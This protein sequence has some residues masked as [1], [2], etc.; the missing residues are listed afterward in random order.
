M[1]LTSQ[2][3]KALYRAMKSAAKARKIKLSA[4][5]DLYKRADPYFYHAFWWPDEMGSGRIGMTLD[6]TVKYCRFAELQYRI[7]RPE[8]E[9]HFT[10]KLRAMPGCRKKTA[11]LP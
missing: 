10:D 11:V 9:P 1:R 5:Y 6:I 4:E 8:A 2:Q 3:H 7:L